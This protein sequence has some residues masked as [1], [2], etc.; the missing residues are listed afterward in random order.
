MT[1]R[2]LNQV[3][4]IHARSLQWSRWRVTEKKEI[5]FFKLAGNI[6]G[7]IT[8][9]DFSTL[10]TIQG[11]SI[12]VVP[13]MSIHLQH[14]SSVENV[15]GAVGIDFYRYPNRTDRLAISFNQAV[16]FI[17][18]N[19]AAYHYRADMDLPVVFSL[20]SSGQIGINTS[21]AFAILN[22][23]GNALIINTY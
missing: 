21:T 17:T 23:F 15:Y 11:P 1:D 22:G 12:I 13:S 2:L 20:P 14:T 4:D 18:N 19:G 16:S 9:N 6:V 7:G 5:V 3:I 8:E 10:A